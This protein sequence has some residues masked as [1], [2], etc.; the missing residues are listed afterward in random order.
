MAEL[1]V[2]V[3]LAHTLM[4]EIDKKSIKSHENEWMEN[5][6]TLENLP[7]SDLFCMLALSYTTYHASLLIFLASIFTHSKMLNGYKQEQMT[8]FCS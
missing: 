2:Q 6:E 4:K 3:Q 8:A 1:A 5:P 7:F